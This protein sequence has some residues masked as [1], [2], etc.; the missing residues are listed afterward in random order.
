MSVSLF[1][2]Q[3]EQLRE[4]WPQIEPKLKKALSRGGAWDTIDIAE[5]VLKGSAQIWGT[6]DGEIKSVWVTSISVYHTKKVCDILACGG[7]GLYELSPY[8]KNVE[9]WAK[10][11]DCESVRIYGRKGWEKVL[12]DYQKIAIVLEK[13]L[14]A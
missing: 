11:N 12:S 7:E 8:I 6:W 5:R 9:T 1:T 4:L 13:K 10:E 3:P 14:N 2:V